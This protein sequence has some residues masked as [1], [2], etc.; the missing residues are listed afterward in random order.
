MIAFYQLTENENA[1]STPR[2]R[3]AHRMVATR[4]LTQDAEPHGNPPPVA[5][6]RSWLFVAW[7]VV[8]ASTYFLHL[9]GV[10]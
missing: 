6:W 9:F 1:V 2:M 3:R 4:F 8:V 7:V 5:A 10:L